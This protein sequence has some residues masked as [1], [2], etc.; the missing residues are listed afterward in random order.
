MGYRIDYDRVREIAMLFKTLG[1]DRVRIFELYDTQFHAAKRVSER[2]PKIS[3]Y[4]LYLNALVSYKLMYYG[5][6]FWTL[7]SQYVSERCSTINSFE[8]A[9]NL[10]IEFTVRYNK[11]MAEH[12]VSRLKRIEKCDEVIR[13]INN[14]EFEL[15]VRHTAKCLYSKPDSKTIVFSVKMIY[16]GLR[17]K[18][19]E[20]ILP[21][22]IPIPVDRR[23]ALLT[24]L[25]GLMEILD[26]GNLDLLSLK[27]SGII[28]EIWQRVSLLS[29]IPPLHIDSVLWYLGKYGY[30]LNN[31]SSIL[32]SIDPHLISKLGRE[33]IK[34]LI[35]N[36]F[37]KLPP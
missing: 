31:R 22:T 32:N 19:F 16:Y 6:R 24:Y 7:F 3:E 26:G 33:T 11:V 9:V 30:N 23:I 29:S 34:F 15:I 8:E 12:K 5:E 25:S 13:D 35:D 14:H 36:L 18:G 17:A 1:I 20:I 27:Y 28:R 10:V 37:Y 4:L 21:S 2:C